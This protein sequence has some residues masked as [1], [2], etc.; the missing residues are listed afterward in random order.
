MAEIL[1]EKN[2]GEKRSEEK[3]AREISADFFNVTIILNPRLHN[4]LP[5]VIS[6]L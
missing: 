6:R 4:V 5:A 3:T 1:G 2:V